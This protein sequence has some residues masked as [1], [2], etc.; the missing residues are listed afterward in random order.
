M[1]R[2]FIPLKPLPESF[3]NEGNIFRIYRKK[4]YPRSKFTISELND[5]GYFSQLNTYEVRKPKFKEIKETNP[6]ELVEGFFF[7]MILIIGLFVPSILIYQAT[8]LIYS[9]PFGAFGG[10][11]A[12]LIILAILSE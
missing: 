3:Q 10:L 2:K 12:V 9:I 11:F 4:R 1:S 8:G 6:R 7:M 5:E